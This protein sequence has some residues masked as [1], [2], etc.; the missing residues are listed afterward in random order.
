MIGPPY[1]RQGHGYR[2]PDQGYSSLELARYILR[3]R[4]HGGAGPLKIV[5][6]ARIRTPEIGLDNFQ[7]PL[8]RTSGRGF[9]D[10]LGLDVRALQ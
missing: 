2:D 3:C 10:S 4:P 1:A 9:Y 5:H 8:A 6:R 7:S